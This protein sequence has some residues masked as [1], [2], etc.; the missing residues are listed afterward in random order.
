MVGDDGPSSVPR[1]RWH[2]VLN[3]GATE[4]KLYSLSSARRSTTP[5]RTRPTPRP[6][7]TTT[8][9]ESPGVLYDG[10]MTS[11]DLNSDLGESF[12]VWRLGDDEALLEIVTSANWRAASTPGT[13][14]RCAPCAPRRSPTT[15]PS[16]PGRLPGPPRLRS[17]YLDIDPRPA[18]AVLYQL[19]A[20]DAFA[21]VAGSEVAYI[22]P[23]GAVPRHDR[24]SGPGRRRRRRGGRVDPR[25]PCSARRVRC[26]CGR[27]RRPASSRSG[28]RS[29]TGPISATDA[30][31]RAPSPTPS[32]STGR[33]GRQGGPPGDRARGGRRR[34]QRGQRRGPLAVRARRLAGRRRAGRAVR[35]AL[36]EAGVGVHPFT[37]DAAVLP[38]GRGRGWWR[39]TRT[40]S[41]LAAASALDAGR[42]IDVVAG[43]RTVLVTARDVAV[44]LRRGW[45]PSSPA[46]RAVATAPWSSCLSSTTARTSVRWRGGRTVHRRGHRPAQRGRYRCAFCGFAPGFG[47]LRGLD[48]A[49]TC[50]ADRRRAGPGG[51]V[52]I[53][54]E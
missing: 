8:R 46:R 42:L 3:T 28:R 43:A 30:W 50:P 54:A 52:A 34:R 49:C 39:P 44:G 51:R 29:P 40:R 48:R 11:I 7:S 37:P 47:Y 18:D 13:R 36:D 12:G 1:G 45:R 53:A 22:K 5:T 16:G 38:C 20:L 24:R 41:A 4:L 27:R 6:T 10:R 19:G 32:S 9:R 35:D 26:C 2:D 21:Q 17:R 33:G 25:S 14:R 23:H 31:C 15:S